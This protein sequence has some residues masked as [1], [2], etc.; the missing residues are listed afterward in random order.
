MPGKAAKLPAIPCGSVACTISLNLRTTDGCSCC[1]ETV[2]AAV[3]K[4]QGQLDLKLL[5]PL[6]RSRSSL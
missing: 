3:A 2:F 1:I 6:A 5:D 4:L